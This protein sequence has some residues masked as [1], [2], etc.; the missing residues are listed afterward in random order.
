MLLVVSLMHTAAARPYT[1]ILWGN[2][3]IDRLLAADFRRQRV[4]RRVS[5]TIGW[6][7]NQRPNL[8]CGQ[9]PRQ[10]STA[11]P[12]IYY[13]QRRAPF[14][15][16][17]I[18]RFLL[19]LTRWLRIQRRRYLNL[20]GARVARHALGAPGSSSQWCKSRVAPRR[21]VRPAGKAPRAR[22]PAVFERAATPADGMQHSANAAGLAPR[23]ARGGWRPGVAREAARRERSVSGRRP[24]RRSRSRC[25][26]RRR[27]CRCRRESWAPGR[28]RTIRLRR[29]HDPD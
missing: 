6:D 7:P 8:T 12:A 18:Q 3:R 1:T 13:A 5:A 2:T 11:P 20:G 21:V 23:A 29:P 9:R 17:H 28:R 19:A 26:H 22:I 25:G 14:I 16:Q 15:K 10:S 4:I 24:D 27:A